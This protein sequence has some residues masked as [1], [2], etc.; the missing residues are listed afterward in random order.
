MEQVWGGAQTP[1]GCSLTVSSGGSKEV[2]CRGDTGVQMKDWHH[3]CFVETGRAQTLGW[4]SG[5]NCEES[6]G[7]PERGEMHLRQGQ[8]LRPQSVP[9][10]GRDDV[11]AADVSS[12]CIKCS[13]GIRH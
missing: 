7:S 11:A 9:A 5:A 2:G 10:S 1:A 4:N 8:R 13:S 3:R 12:T 6:P